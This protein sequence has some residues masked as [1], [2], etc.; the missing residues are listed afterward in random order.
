MSLTRMERYS[1]EDKEKK[2]KDS[3]LSREEK[4]QE[5]YDKA[6]LNSSIVDITNILPLSENDE[7]I[8]HE[9]KIVE[10][11]VYEEKSYDINDYIQKAHE[12][13][14]SDDAKRDLNNQEFQNQEDEIRRLISQI[15][16]K[17][18]SEDLFSD[19]RGDNEDTLIGA[20]MKTDDFDLKIYEIL[21]EDEEAKKIGNTVLNHAIG[22]KT[23]FDMQMEEEKKKDHTFDEIEDQDEKPK[24]KK[25]LP[26]I[27]FVIS[28]S[29]LIGIVLYILLK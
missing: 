20:K 24:K 26:I 29:I 5:V 25:K 3:L 27:I 9:E 10:P 23:I 21:K 14:I 13:Y 16:E 7:E 1:E 28:L 12:K 17:E 19:L 18:S 15:E 2:E 4:N 22:D 8:P 6:Y 11:I